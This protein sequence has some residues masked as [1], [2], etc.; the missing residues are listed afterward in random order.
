VNDKPLKHDNIL[1]LST[2]SSIEENS[3]PTRS[4]L[5]TSVLQEN[6]TDE[7]HVKNLSTQA[8]GRF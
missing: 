2:N 5:R 1:S 6:R 8:I 3:F 7:E 4:I